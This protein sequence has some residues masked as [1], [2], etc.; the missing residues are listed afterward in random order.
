MIGVIADDFTGAAE[1]GGLGLRYGLSVEIR[2]SATSC[3]STDLLIIATDTRSKGAA[4]AIVEMREK[5]RALSELTPHLLYKKL[6]SVLR[7]HV[8]PELAAQMEVLGKPRTLLIPANP[9][10][11][12]T[13]NGGTYYVKGKRLHETSFGQDPEF[14]IRSSDV[15]EILGGIHG[16][17]TALGRLEQALPERGFIVGEVSTAGDLGR[18]ARRVDGTT[19]AAGASGFFAALLEQLDRR[20]LPPRKE[21][22]CWGPNRL[23]VCGSSFS[24]SKKMVKE[25]QTRGKAVKLLPAP[26]T[27]PGAQSRGLAEQCASEIT[28]LLARHDYAVLAADEVKDAA[29]GETARAIR[30]SMAEVTAQ[31]AQ[32]SEIRELLLEGGATAS[33]VLGRLGMDAFYPEQQVAHG[34]IRMR[35]SGRERLHVTMKPGS[36]EWPPEIRSLL[37]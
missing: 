34:V 16:H 23:F 30:E 25:L 7:G 26:L 29:A 36:Y 32:Q 13:I 33:A 14:G 10:F 20:V 12:R 11:D 4:E 2:T 17:P 22:V 19:L 9:A 18:W 27:I 35:I 5:T 1:I 6:D 37:E 15:L 31:V 3:T 21:P 28:E 8:L 24:T